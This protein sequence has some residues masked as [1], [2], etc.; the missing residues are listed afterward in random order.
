M[1]SG[2]L[3]I[4]I[5]P[6]DGYG[7]VD[8]TC[9]PP[10]WC[11]VNGK[12]EEAGTHTIVWSGAGPDGALHTGKSLGCI[13]INSQF[14]KNGIVLFGTR[15]SIGSVRVSPTIFSPNS[16][17]QTLTFTLAMLQNQSANLT[18]SFINQSSLSALRTIQL[19]NQAPGNV[20]VTWDG[21]AGNG[22]LVA[23]GYYTINVNATDSLGNQTL[24]QVLTTVRY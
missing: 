17:T 23:P 19:P 10:N 16:G 5:S 18:V 11:L 15:P 21:R 20:S 8:A 24:G 12:W 7:Q 9:G 2:A 22:M 4:A 1:R 13:T 3:Y 14:P 6:N